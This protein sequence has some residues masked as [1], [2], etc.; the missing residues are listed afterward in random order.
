MA[1]IVGFRQLFRINF[2]FC[3]LL[4]LPGLFFFNQ[5]K[6]FKISVKNFLFDAYLYNRLLWCKQRMIKSFSS[7][8][9]FE[10][11]IIFFPSRCLQRLARKSQAEIEAQA[12]KNQLK[13][14]H[15]V[16]LM[17]LKHDKRNAICNHRHESPICIKLCIKYT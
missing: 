12:L 9:S 7:N 10:S 15:Q 13:Y 14:T 11:N 4:L 2:L 8:F 5:I 16:S 17:A 1:D 6:D 3:F